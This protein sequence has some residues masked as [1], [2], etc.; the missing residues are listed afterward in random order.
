MATHQADVT[1]FIANYRQEIEGAALYNAMADHE[2]VPQLAEVYR[3]LAHV[4]ET[5][6]ELWRRRIVQAGG[7][8]PVKMSWR[9]RILLELTHRF[10][11]SRVLP[12]VASDEVRHQTIYDQQQETQGTSLPN[13]ERSHAR[14]LSLLAARSRHAW[15]GSAYSRLEGKHGA[16][17]ANNLRA[18]VLG[19]NDGLVSTF[20]L[21]MGVAGSTTSPKALLAT[22]LAGT[23]AGACSMAM[24]EWISVQSARELQMRQMASEAEELAHAPAEEQ[25]ELVLIYQAKG[26]TVTQAT[27]IAARVMQNQSSALDTLVREELG[28]NPEDLGGSALMAAFSSFGVFLLGALIPAV[29]LLLTF[30]R[31]FMLEASLLASAIGLLALGATIAL[32]TG[33]HPLFSG[34]R[35]LLIGLGAAGITFGIGHLFGVVMGA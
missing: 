16:G 18:I 28:V 2:P 17:A 9:T 6:A 15:N 29:P 4:E 19:A 23:L 10:G 3:R 32:F 34:I 30:G 13:Q 24:G 11:A 26:F 7:Q 35:Q 5:H 12:W 33:R 1:R 8:V 14:L 27:E 25:E 20:C 22:T 31:T 21:L